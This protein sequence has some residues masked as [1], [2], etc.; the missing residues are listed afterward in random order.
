MAQTVQGHTHSF[1][2]PPTP[3]GYEDGDERWRCDCGARGIDPRRRLI[4]AL[5][6]ALGEQ[7]WWRA[8]DGTSFTPP[9]LAAFIVDEL[10]NDLLSRVYAAL[11]GEDG[12]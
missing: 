7:G 12:K 8:P 10:P 2:R 5:T 6:F 3:A 11:A 4:D 9:F 1:D